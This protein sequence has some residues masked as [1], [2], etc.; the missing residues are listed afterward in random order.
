[1]TEE[2]KTSREFLGSRLGFILLSAGCAIVLGN[3]W[4]FP[5]ITGQYGG[6]IFVCFYL[7]FLILLGFPVMVM[8]LAIG[9]ASRQC[10]IGSYRMLKPEGSRIPWADLGKLFFAGNLILLMFYGVITGWLLSY[11]YDY[12][13]GVFN[14]LKPNDIGT[15]FEQ[16]LGNYTR[17]ILFMFIALAITSGICISGLKSGVERC[18]KFMMAGLLLLIVILAFY[19]MRLDGGMKGVAFFLKPDINS[20]KNHGIWEA[21]HAAMSQAFFTLSLGIGSIAIFGSYAD[22]TKS[23]AQEATII[24]G[25]DTF[26]AI[27]AGL[28]IFPCCFAFGV[29]ADAGPGLIFVTLP[30]IF[31][32]MPQ[33]RLFGSI[34]FLFMSIAAL[35]TLV[36]VAENLIA[37]GIDE[38][39]LN[40]R[41]STTAT[42]ILLFVL[43][44]PCVFGFNIW[45]KFQPFGKGTNVL[46]LEDFI[47]SD[48]LLPLG[49][50]AIVIFCTQK[51]GWG[52]NNF[53]QEA[54]TGSGFKF[55]RAIAGYVT[56]VLPLIILL[57]YIIGL[58]KKIL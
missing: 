10:L 27:C 24:I 48:N 44:L 23:L 50:L 18:T 20:L 53:Y 17:Q 52:C 57:I 33:G 16:F 8:E 42:T 31:L 1:M 19:A 36:A 30:R 55:P 3:I 38:L 32:S 14:F 12:V 6:A 11:T 35:T 26:V 41:I 39:H 15:I 7:L 46:D 37:F 34:F 47:V 56:Y 45:S 25:L 22:K 4:R 40:R 13:I 51:C 2:T 49:A 58:C 54:N 5:Y 21:I 9:R 43:S 28:I 29:E